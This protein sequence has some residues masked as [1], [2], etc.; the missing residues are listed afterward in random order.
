MAHKS[1]CRMIRNGPLKISKSLK[2]AENGPFGQNLFPIT[3]DQMIHM[4]GCI[5]LFLILFLHMGELSWLIESPTYFKANVVVK[6]TI[7]SNL[8]SAEMTVF[9][10]KYHRLW[11]KAQSITWIECSILISIQNIPYW[12]LLFLFKTNNYPYQWNT[13]FSSTPPQ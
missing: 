10:I 2:K 4:I 7:F 12:V 11:H 5:L 3:A 13:C 6:V 1:L 8:L 9:Y